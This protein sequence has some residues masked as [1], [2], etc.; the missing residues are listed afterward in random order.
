MET[1]TVKPPKV[2][3]NMSR[4]VMPG[5]VV[6]TR[7]S[8]GKKDLG[9]PIFSQRRHHCQWC[10]WWLRLIVY[11]FSLTQIW[12]YVVSLRLIFFSHWHDFFIIIRHF[13]TLFCINLNLW[14]TETRIVI[15]R[16]FAKHQFFYNKE[17]RPLLKVCPKIY[18]TGKRWS[19]Q[20]SPR[21]DKSA[22]VSILSSNLIA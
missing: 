22:H 6:V 1:E 18:H 20:P 10:E 21:A 14:F 9:D 2:L 5:F 11:C 3:P 19:S 8:Q 16:H 7:Y 4:K 12:D 15:V 17:S 13:L